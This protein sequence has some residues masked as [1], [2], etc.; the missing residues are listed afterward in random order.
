MSDNSHVLSYTLLISLLFLAFGLFV[1]FKYQ[2][3]LQIL[4]G[5]LGC[6]SYALWGIFHHAGEDRITP[7]VVFEYVSFS[8]ISFL[9]IILFVTLY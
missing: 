8:L 7:L 4:L 5:L 2:P 1:H 3:H 6:V 9:L